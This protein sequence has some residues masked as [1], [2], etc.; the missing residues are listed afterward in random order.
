[1]CALADAPGAHRPGAVLFDRDGTL[2]L[3][4]PYNG[5]PALVVAVPGARTALDRLRAEGI[6]TAVVSNQSGIARGWLTVQQVEAVNHRM[7]ELLGP[8]GPVLYCP[9]GTDDDCACRKP[10]PGLLVQAARVLGV[11]PAQC[12][13]IG[14]IGADVDAALAVGARPV[15]VPTAHTRPDEVQRAPEVAPDLATAV[16]RLLGD[17]P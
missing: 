1:M 5:D 7:E 17:H 2:V 11:E 15:L 12:A 8:L 6:P 13:L 10:R 9:H 4:V 16:G 14:D 3:D